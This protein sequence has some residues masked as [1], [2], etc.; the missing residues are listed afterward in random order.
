[1]GDTCVRVWH[2][3]TN[4][5][6]AHTGAHKHTPWHKIVHAI[7]TLPTSGR[8]RN[9]PEMLGSIMIWLQVSREILDLSLENLAVNFIKTIK[10]LLSSSSSRA[11]VERR[12]TWEGLCGHIRFAILSLY[13]V[14]IV[15]TSPSKW[16]DL[17]LKRHSFDHILPPRTLM[18]LIIGATCSS[19]P[20]LSEHPW[21]QT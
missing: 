14:K 8:G 2:K 12:H 18:A 19:P 9:H 13:A 7:W 6:D 10:T 3:Y 4:T 21:V 20:G 1:M 11:R 15:R 16:D 17:T 5:K